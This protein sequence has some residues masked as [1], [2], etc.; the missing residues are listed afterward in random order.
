M[1]GLLR[2]TILQRLPASR[3]KLVRT[4]NADSAT[5]DAMLEELVSKG[6]IEEVFEPG[7]PAMYYEVVGSCYGRELHDWGPEGGVESPVY[8]AKVQSCA[9]C[10]RVRRVL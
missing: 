6:R 4:I 10:G 8:K 3:R 1:A 7:K 2:V 5:I 9:R